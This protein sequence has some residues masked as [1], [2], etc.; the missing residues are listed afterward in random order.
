VLAR[1]A[2]RSFAR[3][4]ARACD[5]NFSV[6][7][8]RHLALSPPFAFLGPPPGKPRVESHAACQGFTL[9]PAWFEAE[10]SARGG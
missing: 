6:G 8:L 9:P 10:G 2:G 5:S 7:F 4:G 3:L 1:A